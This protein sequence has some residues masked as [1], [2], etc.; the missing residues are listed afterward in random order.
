MGRISRNTALA[1]QLTVIVVFS[2]SCISTKTVSIE[3]PIPAKNDLPEHIQSLTIVNRTVDNRYT[4]VESD[5]LQKIFYEQRFNYDTVIYDLQS[6]DTLLQALGGLLFESGRYDVVI[7]VERFLKFE[8]NAFLTNEMDWNEVKALC[9]TFETD[10][11]LS[12]DHFTT[13]VSTEFDSDTFFD[14]YSNSFVS[15]PVASMKVYY[16]AL[17]RVY[18]TLEQKVISRE[19]FRDTLFWEDVDRTTKSLMEKFTPVKQ[20]LTEAGIAVALDYTDK[21]G[22]V[23]RNERRTYFA[24]G[25]DII[26]QSGTL[27]NSGEVVPAINLLKEMESNTQAKGLR[28]KA[29]YNLAVAYELMGDTNSAIAWALKSYETM[30]RLLTYEYLE[31][32]K[33]RKDEL[34]TQKK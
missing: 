24:K 8:R 33:R 31:I 1:L 17:I 11:V 16:E 30:Y 22:T 28:S 13:R 18:D 26:K 9:D 14:Q 5:S 20:A 27:I 15:A 29:Q 25:N 21:I 10:A 32:L 19:F 7:P 23:W 6:A 3:I 2:V 34:K 12:V 4:D